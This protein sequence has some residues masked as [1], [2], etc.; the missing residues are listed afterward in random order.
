MK[1]KYKKLSILIPAYNEEATV[2]PLLDKVKAT[3]IMLTK[4][5][6]VVDNNSRDRTKELVS[7]WIIKNKDV[8][9]KLIVEKIPGKG[10]AVRSAIKAAS[11]DILIIQD[12]DLEYD[13][14]DYN[15]LLKPI[16]EHK[17]RV[18]YGNRLGLKENTTA[19]ISFYLG[20]RIM[21]IA[22]ALIFG[23]DLKDI[24]TCYKA[25]DADL[26]KNVD[27]KE[28]GFAFDFAEITPFFIKSLRKDKK[29]IAII[30]IHFYP[31]TIAQ[32]KKIKWQDGVYGVWAMLKYRFRNI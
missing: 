28:K 11:G 16:L 20:G 17:T 13:P 2:A 10:A 23:K 8:T 31:R 19:H 1:N 18:V 26:T 25:W 9:A 30:P 22:G 24:N 27:F 3:S 7:D 5:I 21:T 12:A 14:K 4:E 15:E 32:G 29:E 6:I